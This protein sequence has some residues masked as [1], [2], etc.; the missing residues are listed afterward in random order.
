M[1]IDLILAVAAL[2]LAVVDGFVPNRWLLNVA[3]VCLALTF[4]L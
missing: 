4:L 2:I 3:I 1:S